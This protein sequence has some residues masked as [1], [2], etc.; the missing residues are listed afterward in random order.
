MRVAILGAGRIG[1]VHA[2]NIAGHAESVLAAVVDP[3]PEA[4]RALAAKYGAEV[5]TEDAVM[6]D[7]AIDAVVIAS[8]TQRHADQAERAAAAGKAIFFEKPVDLSMPRV[9]KV[10]QT[11]KEHPVPFMLGF[12]RR[13]DPN[14][15]AL[16]GQIDAGA[17]GAVEMV[18]ILSRDPAPPPIDYIKVSGGIF[19]D[20]MIHDLDIARWLVGED[21]TQVSAHGAVHV[22]PA[23]GEAG[24]V[25]T[26]IV[27]LKSKSGV[28]VGISNSRRA[29]YGYDQRIEVHG[30][31]GMVSAQNVGEST[32]V[33]ATEG[34]VR[35]EKPKHFFLERYA[36]AYAREWVAF[37]DL[38]KG[39]QADVPGIAEGL[40]SLALAER[41]LA[42]SEAPG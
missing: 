17:I 25:D 40:A 8:S 3:Y 15:A 35:L 41:A 13:F 32:M 2:P 10:A 23:I 22:D 16:K 29:A 33:L 39:R 18:T 21:F 19:R 30:A 31:K 1:Q 37:V 42:A 6:A 11:L 20:M 9:E 14:F 12:N 4:A 38:V 5:M 34:G 7:A 36:T 24:D 28:L 26:A 27:T